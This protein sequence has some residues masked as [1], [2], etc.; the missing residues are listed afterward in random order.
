MLRENT[1]GGGL[2]S[3]ESILTQFPNLD[4]QIS[5]DDIKNVNYKEVSEI[6]NKSFLGE[7]NAKEAK[8]LLAYFKKQ[9]AG[10]DKSPETERRSQML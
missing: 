6:V 8:I 7:I 4:S 9:E 3:E 2:T 1:A 10:E 5:E